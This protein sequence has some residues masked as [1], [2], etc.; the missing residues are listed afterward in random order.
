MRTSVVAIMLAI[1]APGAASAQ[2]RG[3]DIQSRFQSPTAERRIDVGAG[4]EG[5][6][7]RRSSRQATGPDSGLEGRLYL[8][9]RS[10]ALGNAARQFHDELLERLLAER[11]QLVVQRRDEAIRLLE[12]FVREEPEN[13]PEMP[14]AL[15]RLAELRWELAR[16]QHIEAY[17]AWQQVPEENRGPEPHPDYTTTLEL[18]DRILQRHRGFDRYD[19]VLY[20]KAF[21]MVELGRAEEALALYRRILV[22]FPQSR[23]VPDAHM[24]F[25]ETEFNQGNFPGALTEYELVLRH[26]DSDLYGM[27]LF[28]SAWCLWRMARSQEAAT[29]FRQVLD[30]GRGRSSQRVSAEQRRRLQELQ[31]EALEYLIQVFTEDEGNTARDVFAFLEGIGGERY[32]DRVLVR[33]SA[34]FYEQQRWDRGIEAYQ[35]LLER[36]PGDESAPRWQLRVAAGF[37]AV[38]DAEHTIQALEVLADRYLEGG[39]WVEQQSDPEAVAETRA[40]IEQAV[41]VRGMRYHDLGQRESQRP[42]FERAERMYAIYLEH[43]GDEEIAYNIRFYRGEILFHRLERF[44][45]A[46]QMYLAAAQQNPQGQYT[47][48]ALYNSISAFERVREAQLGRC[49]SQRASGQ[50]SPRPQ[51]PQ[52]APQQAPQPAAPQQAQGQASP[53]GAPPPSPFEEDPCG[54]TEN[55]RRFATAIELYVE[56]YPNDPDLPEIL[57]RQGR[58]YY[59]RQIYDPAVRLFGQ[60]LERF[61]NSPYAV[62]AGELILESFNRARDFENIETWARRLKSSPAF[63]TPESQ[64]RL[65]AL[66][67]QA[68]FARGEQLARRNQHTEAAQAYLRAAAEF[69]NDERAPQAYFNAGVEY[70]RGGNVG[71][72][73]QAYEQLAQRHPGNTIAANGVWTGAQMFESIAQFRDAAHFYELYAQGFPNGEHGA[74]ALFNA[75]LLRATAQD[76]DLAVQDGNRFLERFP[77]HDSA[78][79]VTFFIARAQ[80]SAQRWAE[81]AE[82]YR[83]YVRATRNPNREVE[84]TTRLAQVLLRTNDREGADRALAQAVRMGRHN[85]AQLQGGLYYAAQARFMQAEAILREYE[86]IQ[87]AGPMD[88]LRQ[89]LERK[90]ELLRRAAEAF[91]DVVQFNVAEWVTASLFQIGRSYELFASGLREAPVPEGLSEEEEIAYQDQL[92]SFIVPIEE[93]ALEAFEGGYQTALRMR[94]FNRWT[95][96]L[97]VGL[98]RLNDVQ[99]PPFREMGGD[100]EQAAR[101]P[102]PPPLEGLRRGAPEP[103]AEEQPIDT[104]VSGGGGS[105]ET[106]PASTRRRRRRP[107]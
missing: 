14:D 4:D 1:L 93:R 36:L 60:L 44:D 56:Q 86:A 85:R 88:G 40:M 29:R 45:E 75:T 15:L 17:G 59:D 89:R 53:E 52:P 38:G 62:T 8:R 7:S 74:D 20:M 18:Y 66:I 41:R 12:E 87:I 68:V 26:P 98:T 35:L 47:R 33:L 61:P 101:I 51:A 9:E 6:S 72:A 24:A 23:F 16:T 83:R 39:E 76:H 77:R 11:E 25:A 43:F 32:A 95:E 92:N 19:L 105:P 21:A 22:E 46:G 48:D 69:P 84:A 97:R 57:F 54:E 96:Q 81:A 106:T 30:L 64:R 28:K 10:D 13:A 65:D 103:P 104:Q 42:M 99:Y 49:T 31:D 67:L 100:I 2:P 94:I 3:A 5:G 107:R 37:A 50:P 90:S 70:Q 27:A 78:S 91:A 71:G 55:D 82:T 79:D 34:R 102:L 58:L 80:E 73:A 63:A